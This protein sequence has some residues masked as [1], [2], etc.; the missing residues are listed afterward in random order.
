[1]NW[2]NI[3]STII[4]IMNCNYTIIMYLSFK[5]LKVKGDDDGIPT[6]WIINKKQKLG[7][8]VIGWQ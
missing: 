3:I 1:M 7:M 6:V 4:N 5:D 8:C 2:L